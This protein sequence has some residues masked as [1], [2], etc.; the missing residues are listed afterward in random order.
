[1]RR[2]L[3]GFGLIAALAYAGIDWLQDNVEVVTLHV[4]GTVEDFYPRLFVVDDGSTVWVRAE[5]PDRLWLDPLRENPRVVLQRGD[6]D[7]TY[8]AQVWDGQGSHD[9]VDDLFRAKYGVLDELSGWFWRRD[10]VPIRLEPPEAFATSATGFGA[11]APP[12][13]SRSSIPPRTS[14]SRRV[15]RPRNRRGVGGRR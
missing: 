7:I 12:P 15:P 5:R 3:L 13:H 10:A 6:R 4:S 11:S 1:V 8:H 14:R 2:G 9:E